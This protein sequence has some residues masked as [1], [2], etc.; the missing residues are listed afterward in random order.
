[1]LLIWYKCIY[2]LKPILK[3]VLKLKVVCLLW[4]KKC[5]N[6]FPGKSWINFHILFFSNSDIFFQTFKNDILSFKCVNFKTDYETQ[7]DMS[8][9]RNKMENLLNSCQETIFQFFSESR[10]ITLSFK[11]SFGLNVLPDFETIGS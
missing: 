3:L 4:K 5:V 8:A 6:L 10:H 9:L 7:C 11:I 1:M 2:T